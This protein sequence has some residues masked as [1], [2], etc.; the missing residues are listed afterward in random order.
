MTVYSNCRMCGQKATCEVYAAARAAIK[1]NAR[2]FGGVRLACK[3]V[4]QRDFPRGSRVRVKRWDVLGDV[5]YKT[6][7]HQGAT[8]TIAFWGK[9][10]KAYVYLDE[11][12]YEEGGDYSADR[13]LCQMQSFEH[14]DLAA[15]EEPQRTFCSFCDN[16][17]GPDGA[18]V[19]WSGRNG[20][21]RGGCGNA[22]YGPCAIPAPRPEHPDKD[23]SSPPPWDDEVAS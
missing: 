2:L 18:P 13:E 8:G 11:E 19:K 7:R 22:G 21:A 16:L 9:S 23:D 20:E 6:R 10:G 15:L 4:Y 14:R 12:Q 3:K 5:S 1:G 17:I